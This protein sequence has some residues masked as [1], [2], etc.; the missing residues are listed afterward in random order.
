MVRRHTAYNPP[1]CLLYHLR[2]LLLST[3]VGSPKRGNVPEL[4]SRQA[5]TVEHACR[6]SR[7]MFAVSSKRSTPRVLS[8]KQLFPEPQTYI[9][10]K[11]FELRSLEN[12]FQMRETE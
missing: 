11:S 1:K 7:S 3:A 6:W 10:Q 8:E 4:L 2:F 12:R 9:V 5:I